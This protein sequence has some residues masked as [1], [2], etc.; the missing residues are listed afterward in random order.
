MSGHFYITTPIY[1]VNARPHLGHAYTTIIA[2]VATRFNEMCQRDVFFLTGTDEHGDKVVRAAKKENLSSRKYVDKISSLFRALWPEL[3]I[4]NNHFIRTTDSSHIAVV[5]RIL[6]KIYD[7]GDIYFSQYE[8]LYCFGCERFY[9]ERELVDGKCPDHET[10]PEVIKETNYFFKMSKYQDWL[11]DHINNNPDFIRPQRY[12]NEVLSFLK[13]PLEDLCISRPKT[14]LKWGITL[15]F[16]KDY[17][18]YVWFDALLNYVSALGFP[19]G[20]LFKNYWPVA[21]HIVAKDI[22]KP[23]GIYWPI[24]LK[25]AGIDTYRHLNVHGYWNVDQSKMSKSLGNAV[26]PL[27][28]KEIYGLDQFRFFLIR[29]MVFGLDSNF[30]EEAFVQR[31]NSDLAN[32]LGNLFSRVLSMAHKY[33]DGVVP[34]A[35]LIAEEE[36]SFSLEADAMTAVDEVEKK[37][38]IFAFHKA[39][40]AIWVFIGCMNKYI[41]VNAPWVLAK[42]KSAQE[43]LKTIIYNLLEGLRIISGMI[44]PVMPDTALMMQKHLG[45][46][47]SVPFYTFKQLHRWKI[48]K[49]GTKLLKSIT[50]FPRIDL[51]KVKADIKRETKAGDKVFEIKPEVTFEEFSKI[52]FKVGTVVHVE[53]IPKAKKLLKLEVDIGEKRTIVAGI[54]ESYNSDDLKGKQVLIAANL[55]P[56]KIMGTLSNGMLLAAVD[57]Q[58]C[59]I[60]TF[61]KKMKP[62]TSV[63]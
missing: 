15:P 8:G 22:L 42:K 1:Y 55:K 56:A 34:E 20:D 10:A 25:A 44:Y 39:L 9:T 11:I 58:G 19:D 5:E 40:E 32:D 48:L 45:M 31:I 36:L 52:D 60:A 3:N 4:K 23:H 53:A 7:S 38:E 35:D 17:V 62:G 27:Q 30:S 2:D 37:M 59:S 43:Q 63:R 49:P 41:D 50:L 33:F 13:E 29:D 28:L 57:N 12:K 47:I 18:T 24:M 54:S 16:D 61:D 6:Q 46:D 21:Q 26:E 14:R 51:K